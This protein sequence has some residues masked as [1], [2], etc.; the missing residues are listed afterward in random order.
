MFSDQGR[1]AARGEDE[2]VSGAEGRGAAHS[3]RLLFSARGPCVCPEN[4]PE[5]ADVETTRSPILRTLGAQGGA[6]RRGGGRG[7][8]GADRERRCRMRLAAAGCAHRCCS[9][10]R[11]CLLGAS[12]KV[13]LPGGCPARRQRPDRFPPVGVWTARPKNVWHLMGIMRFSGERPRG[14]GA[15]VPA[16]RCGSHDGECTI[17]A[18]LRCPGEKRCSRNRAAK[19]PEI[20]D[21]GELFLRR[22]GAEIHRGRNGGAADT[23]RDQPPARHDIL[24]PARPHRDGDVFMRGGGLFSA[25]RVLL[26]RTDAHRV[27]ERHGAAAAGRL[28]TCWKNRMPFAVRRPEGSGTRIRD[29]KTDEQ[30]AGFPTDCAGQSDGGA[31][32]F[33]AEGESRIRGDGL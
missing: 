28:R 26:R 25:G 24:R 15:G 13:P 17:L 33:W 4:R 19:E 10:V 21:S 23:R 7:R 18:A 5:I 12:V 16:R 6:V 11:C 3:G 27:A 22:A 1:G 31:V 30:P 20:T 9:P 14:H 2:A 29:V 8:G 32:L